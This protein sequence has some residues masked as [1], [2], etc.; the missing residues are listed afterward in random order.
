[1]HDAMHFRASAKTGDGVIEAFEHLMK[2]VDHEYKPQ[3]NPWTDPRSIDIGNKN[4]RKKK[5]K[6]PRKQTQGGNCC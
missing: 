3:V 2:R 4:K 5:V 1:M 6:K